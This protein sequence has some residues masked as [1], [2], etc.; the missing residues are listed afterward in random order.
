MEGLNIFIAIFIVFLFI[1][2]IKST[3]KSESFKSS[4]IADA[5]RFSRQDTDDARKKCYNVD[6]LTY[7]KAQIAKNADTCT[8][9]TDSDIYVDKLCQDKLWKQAGCTKPNPINHLNEQST[10]KIDLLNKFTSLFKAPLDSADKISCNGRPC[11]SFLD[12]DKNLNQDCIN[13]LWKDNKCT[14]KNPL[15]ATDFS[16]FDKKYVNSFI[17]GY[18]T[19]GTDADKLTC[20]GEP[21][22]NIKD[23]D[24]NIDQH[25]YNKIWKDKCTTQAPPINDWTKSQTLQIL[26]DDVKL[27]STMDTEDHRKGCYGLT[28][29]QYNNKFNIN[30]CI[31]IKETDANVDELCMKKVWNEVGCTT[32]SIYSL[33]NEWTR[34]QTLADT[35]NDA[36]IWA[37]NDTEDH[38]KGCYNMTREQ[39]NTK[40]N[41]NPCAKYKDTD[42]NIDELCTKKI[43]GDKCKTSNHYTKD[44]ASKLW[45]AGQTLATIKA[46][47]DSWA[48]L[49]TPERRKGCHNMT[50]Y[51]YNT[52]N[53]IT[54][55]CISFPNDTDKITSQACY[56]KLWKDVGCT[57]N[58]PYD[59]NTVW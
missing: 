50:Q 38:R 15:L 44:E 13:Q 8:K 9:Y 29:E 16:P 24:T 35:R 53:K 30:P 11:D 26:K 10:K 32:P 54:D 31:N 41:I 36:K 55:P 48:K 21:C 27:W 34:K 57:T 28:R 2:I 4:V 39:Y 12:T 17:N 20:Y 23:T 14:T 47:A 5:K 18:A 52:A 56:E 1:V 37:T 7:E 6:R 3:N 49:D 19:S 22:A 58:S 45:T 51:E 46:D 43:W 40:F 25:C 42:V 59:L 33:S